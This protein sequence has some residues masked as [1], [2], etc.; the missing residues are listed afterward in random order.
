MENYKESVFGSLILLL[1]KTY[2]FQ[3]PKTVFQNVN[4]VFV[5][6]GRPPICI[7]INTDLLKYIMFISPPRPNPEC[8]VF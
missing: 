4:K 7:D 3:K 8:H 6:L 1:H 5:K 2:Y